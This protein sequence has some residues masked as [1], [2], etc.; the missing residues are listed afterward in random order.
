MKIRFDLNSHSNRKEEVN[1]PLKQT[2][3]LSNPASLVNLRRRIIELFSFFCQIRARQTKSAG[4]LL[5]RVTRRKSGQ[6]EGRKDRAV[7]QHVRGHCARNTLLLND[8]IS[9]RFTTCCLVTGRVR[10]VRTTSWPVQSFVVKDRSLSPSLSFFL[11]LWDPII[12][13]NH[14]DAWNIRQRELVPCSRGLGAMYARLI[15][16]TRRV[17]GES[18]TRNFEE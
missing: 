3:S 16:C 12:G 10:T 8:I 1:S 15:A 4:F 17:Y 14:G 5:S 6:L 7:N 11:S 13:S 2:R 9:S 18:A